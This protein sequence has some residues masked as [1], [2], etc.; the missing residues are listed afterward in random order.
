MSSLIAYKN[1]QPQL[2]PNVWIAPGAH[3]IGDVT[4]GK[5]S[6]IWFNCVLRGDVMPIIIGERTNIQDLTMIHTSDGVLPIS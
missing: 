1:K 6:G 5:D 3:I 2:D 4:V